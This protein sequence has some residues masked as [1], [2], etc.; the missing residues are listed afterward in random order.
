MES[1]QFILQQ[2]RGHANETCKRRLID[3][4]ETAAQHFQLLT[5]RRA[6]KLQQVQNGRKNPPNY[7][8]KLQISIWVTVLDRCA[9][10]VIAMRS[11][12]D[13]PV[14][15]PLAREELQGSQMLV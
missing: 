4:E 12:L 3:C 8:N 6:W 2:T 11:G 13:T 15:A 5:E 14:A 10:K 7:R 9:Q 1:V